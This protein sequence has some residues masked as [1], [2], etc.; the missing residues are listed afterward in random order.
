MKKQLLLFTGI[1][2]FCQL[3]A[4]VQHGAL[5]AK[6]EKTVGTSADVTVKPR[7]IKPKTTAIWGAGA[8]VGVADGEF[9]N[10]FINADSFTAGDNPTAWTAHSVLDKNATPG[11]AYWTRNLT[12]IGQG[13]Y[14]TSDTISS[15]SQANG[16]ALFDSDFMDNAGNPGAWA[17]GTSPSPHIGD[18][19]SPRID[20]TGYTDKALAVNFYGFYRKY[21]ITELSVSMS[22]DDGATWATVDYQPLLPSLT[23]D[24]VTAVFASITSGVS[25]LSQCRIK[26][27]FNGDYYFAF[28][29]DVNIT[30]AAAYDLAFG[31]PDANSTEFIDQGDQT[32]ITGNRYFPISHLD[33]NHHGNFGANVFNRG[34]LDITENDSCYLLLNIEKNNN[35]LWE[36]VYTDSLLVGA[37]ASGGFA[38]AS[39]KISDFSWARVGD[40]RASYSAR[41]NVIDGNP[42]N[43]SIMHEFTLTPNNYASLVNNNSEGQLEITRPVIS[44]G[45]PYEILEYGSVFYFD[46]PNSEI[47]LDSLSYRYFVPSGFIGLETQ[48]YLAN[49][50]EVDAS[51]GVIDNESRLT[52]VGISSL[53]LSG[54]GTDIPNGSYG[55]GTFTS[56]FDVNSGE[57]LNNLAG[58]KHYLIS[59][60]I[61][62]DQTTNKVSFTS[63]DVLWFGVS[64][65]K[66]YYLNY[67]STAAGNVIHPSPIMNTDANGVT[68]WYA[69]GY[70]ADMVPSIGLHITSNLCVYAEPTVDFSVIKTGETIT[71]MDA[72]TISSDTT[73]W[74][75]DFGDGNTSTEQNPT[76]TYAADGIYTVCLTV[77]D[78]CVSDSTC[79]QVNTSTVGISEN[80]MENINIY[81]VPATDVLQINGLKS[82]ETYVISMVNQ[83]G[84]KVF[85]KTYQGENS[86]RMD[87]NSLPAGTYHLNIISQ[88][89]T[90]TRNIVLVK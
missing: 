51:S 35:G 71:F 54:L 14:R 4:Q 7:G 29:D 3:N 40:F 64:E 87:V 28:V 65:K 84:Q 78:D 10:A 22:V 58:G 5:Q 69:V 32:H 81:P 41:A 50:Y 16:V 12:G 88:Q 17:T 70:G 37:I 11:N 77:T 75:W 89:E 59:I 26:F 55:T 90:I 36:P 21:D 63:D 8:A 9:A 25:N 57:K 68:T 43:N 48:T 2:G 80:G 83:L 61:R 52:F 73:T 18:L 31:I 85:T 47:T 66:N 72:S 45:G 23:E 42:I 44:G 15:P 19:I 82:Q 76:H 86:I 62:F 74:L 24:H 13:A 27:R 38:N 6:Q 33:I 67:T 20:L 79:S 1:I 34:I 60:Q 46:N 30:E 56:F 53:T 39:G 49:I